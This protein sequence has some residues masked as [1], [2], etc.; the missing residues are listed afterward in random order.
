MKVVSKKQLLNIKTESP[1]IVQFQQEEYI[2]K[3]IEKL[4]EYLKTNKLLK[5]EDNNK[6]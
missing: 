4:H 2:K 6:R 1:E 5:N 3:V